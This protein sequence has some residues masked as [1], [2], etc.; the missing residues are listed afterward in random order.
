MLA[1]HK[2]QNFKPSQN[3][4]PLLAP[5]MI[6]SSRVNMTHNVYL[7]A[8]LAFTFSLTAGPFDGYS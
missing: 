8:Y 4:E 2:F 3:G 1:R 5:A 6:Y 7:Y